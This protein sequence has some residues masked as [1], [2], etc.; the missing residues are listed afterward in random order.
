MAVYLY[1]VDV[2]ASSRDPWRTKD[3]ALTEAQARATRA[4]YQKVLGK[5]NVRAVR[6]HKRG[7]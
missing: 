4:H 1:R 5:S 7:K 6:T 2:R 3:R